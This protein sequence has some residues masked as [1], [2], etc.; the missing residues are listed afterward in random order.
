M[1]SPVI[2]DL[3]APALALYRK[4][5]ALD[6]LQA[7]DER[8]VD[9]G[10]RLLHTAQARARRQHQMLQQLKSDPHALADAATPAYAETPATQN[11]DDG[12][13][14]AIRSL[15][16]KMAKLQSDWTRTQARIADML[17]RSET[18]LR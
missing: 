13:T 15:E 8:R 17:R 14:S 12:V 11:P 9:H 7:R 2:Q 1:L 5:Q 6:R 16:A 10:L 3:S 18:L 4:L